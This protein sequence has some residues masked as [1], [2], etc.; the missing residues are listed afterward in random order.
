MTRLHLWWKLIKAVLRS[1]DDREFYDRIAPIY[2]RIF[3]MHRLHAGKMV[4]IL[5][6][7]Y[8]GHHETKR[9]LDLG[10]GTGILT[11]MLARK[12]FDVI[13]LDFSLESLRQLQRQAGD[14]PIVSADALQL[15]FRKESMD[16]VVS[17]G[18]WRHFPDPQGVMTEI[19]RV[20]KP[21]GM[22][23]V[24]YFPPALG[25]LLP[26]RDNATGRLLIRCYRM[27]IKLSGYT[28]RADFDLEQETLELS[29]RYFE[30]VESMTCSDGRR[31]IVARKPLP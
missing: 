11:D 28:D 30:R 15:P 26:L 31:I 19:E 17:L 2:D 29:H 16:A 14:I 9:V 1:R 10:C 22:L 18:A 27:M 3:I 8:G 25:G 4:A 12:H 20:T 23:L 24:G 6:E 7:A 13:G 5:A 21:G